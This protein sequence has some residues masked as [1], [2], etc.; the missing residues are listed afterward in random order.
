MDGLDDDDLNLFGG[1]GLVVSG[2]SALLFEAPSFIERSM[3]SLAMTA[4]KTRFFFP[5]Q[6]LDKIWPF[7]L[8][9]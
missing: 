7:G 2:A 6:K 8:G 1:A 3:G 5:Q 4:C 9:R